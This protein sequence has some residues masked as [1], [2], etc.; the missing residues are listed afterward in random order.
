QCDLGLVSPPEADTNGSASHAPFANDVVINSHHSIHRQSEADAFGAASACRDHRID[1]DHLAPD[2]Q[3]WTTAVPGIDRRI[4]LNKVLEGARSA[5]DRLRV[6]A[7]CA[8]DSGG[9]SRFETKRRAYG[10]RPVSHLNRIGISDSDRSQGVS[11]V[12]LD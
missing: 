11:H 8:D 4:G 6:A 1:A 10:N 3:Q 7:G 12:D 9:Y 5:S 2:V